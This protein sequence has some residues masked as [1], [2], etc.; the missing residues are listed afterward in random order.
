MTAAKAEKDENIK[1]L[2]RIRPPSRTE[3]ASGSYRKA[4]FVSEDG[5]GAYLSNC[6]HQDASKTFSYDNVVDEETSQEK[7]FDLVGKPLADAFLNGYHCNLLAYGQTG[8]GKT[9]TMQGK[10]ETDGDCGNGE[11]TS[12]GDDDSSSRGLL[13]RVLE[14]V[15]SDLER[16]KVEHAEKSLGYAYSAKVSHL[17]IYNEVI[18][19]LLDQTEDKSITVREDTKKGVMVDGWS[20][21]SVANASE[22][23]ALF[24]KGCKSRHIGQTAAN[25]E[26]S[27]SHSVFILTQEQKFIDADTGLEKRLKTSF[28]LVDLA[29]SERQKHSEAVGQTLKEACGINKSLSTLG[30]V[31]KSLVDINE[32]KERHIPYRDS[33][34]TF[35]LKNSFGGMSKCSFVAN[36]SP[37]LAALE[38]TLSTLKLAQRAKTVKNT[39]KLCEETIGSTAALQTELTKV[40]AELL[41]LQAEGPQMMTLGN[42]VQ[43]LDEES[44]NHLEKMRKLLSSERA[45]HA[46]EREKLASQVGALQGLTKKLDTSLKA[47]KL[48]VRLREQN[49][50]RLQKQSQLPLAPAEFWEEQGGAAIKENEQLKVQLECHPEVVKSRMEIETLQKEREDLKKKLET[51]V[52][53]QIFIFEE[54]AKTAME[55]LHYLLRDRENLQSDH[56]DLKRQFNQLKEENLVDLQNAQTKLEKVF[57]TNQSLEEMNAHANKECSDLKEEVASLQSSVADKLAIIASSQVAL[58]EVQSQLMEHLKL[59]DEYGNQVKTLT[60]EIGSMQEQKESVEASFETLKSEMDAQKQAH[61]EECTGLNNQ[62]KTLT[63]EKETV[64][65]SFETLKSEMDAQKQAHDEECTG[66]NNQVKTLTDEKETVEASFET[67]KSEMDAQKQS[68]AEVTAQLKTE[69]ENAKESCTSLQSEK[70]ALEYKLKEAGESN[71]A[72]RDAAA[73]KISELQSLVEDLTLKTATI[74]SEESAY[75]DK[76]E[77]LEK[78]LNEKQKL[79]EESANAKEDLEGT[80]NQLQDNVTDLEKRCEALQKEVSA[81]N[82]LNSNSV[83]DLES[84]LSAATLKYDEALADAS[85]ATA[86][87]ESAKTELEDQR[88]D[89]EE[90]EGSLASKISE[91]EQ[92]L[93]TVTEDKSSVETRLQEAGEEMAALRSKATG[94]EASKATISDLRAALKRAQENE[95]ELKMK[96]RESLNSCNTAMEEVR[97]LASES[98]AMKSNEGELEERLAATTT[99]LQ[100]FKQ[101]YSESKSERKALEQDRE[102]LASQVDLEAEKRQTAVMAKV[103]SESKLSEV[104][105]EAQELRKDLQDQINLERVASDKLRRRIR[106]LELDAARS[107]SPSTPP[108]DE[109]RLRAA[110]MGSAQRRPFGEISNKIKSIELTPTRKSKAADK[111]KQLHQVKAH[112]SAIEN[113]ITSRSSSRY[114][115]RT[116]NRVQSYKE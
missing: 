37:S 6:G 49:L 78:E 110:K 105:E 86:A 115:L 75:L 39:S 23:Y 109:N 44:R 16:K 34:L 116:R 76:L 57:K 65:A 84:K 17:E 33:K 64:E 85:K 103:Q 54:N 11:K 46:S 62:V 94:A 41:R 79:L 93:A 22:A 25:R 100:R 10:D 56:E 43:N 80:R 38:E 111:S 15:F 47:T 108:N 2:M 89:H 42:V 88:K 9:Y 12:E 114:A 98:E 36:V 18:F 87:M 19:D 77:A 68:D 8:A 107:Q 74:Q 52:E 96:S 60:E 102:S 55:E 26:S 104:R 72:E 31:I 99:E 113:A 66:L 3:L 30:N 13:P 7:V 20:V 21:E 106:E 70:E 35:L 71:T 73:E 69:L 90:K 81:L 45:A 27:K 95:A 24:K 67:L 50:E 97:K 83:A 53:S 92:D 14:Y 4:V 29:G 101:L 58:E 1:V 28:Y 51:D 112:L 59:C 32:G 91:L 48:V 82:E 5:R 61:D 40:K 63:D